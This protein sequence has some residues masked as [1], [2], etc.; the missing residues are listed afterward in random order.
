MRLPTVRLAVGVTDKLVASPCAA[1]CCTNAGVELADDGVTAFEAADGGPV[2][3]GLLA[4][5]VKV[6]QLPGVNPVTAT[7][8]GGGVPLTVVGVSGVV[9]RYGV[10]V[11][12][13]V[14]PPVEGALQVT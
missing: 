11:Y 9:P 12:E 10:T 2:P 14:G 1:T 8:V 7:P 5:T 13:V 6:Y 4:V 3:L